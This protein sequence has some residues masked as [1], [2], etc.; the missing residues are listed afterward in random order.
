MLVPGANIALKV[1]RVV[2]QHQHK[3]GGQAGG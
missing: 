2:A 1:G 3:S